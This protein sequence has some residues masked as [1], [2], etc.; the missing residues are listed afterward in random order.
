[1]ALFPRH[2]RRGKH[3]PTKVGGGNPDVVPAKAGIQIEKPG[4]RIKS[5]M[6]KLYSHCR[7]TTLSSVLSGTRPQVFALGILIAMVFDDLSANDINDVLGDVRGVVGHALQM[8]AD[9]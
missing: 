1:M 7:N 4:F 8:P 5:G 2:S 3:V 6:T 9:Q